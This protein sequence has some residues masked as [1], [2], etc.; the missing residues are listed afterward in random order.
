MVSRNNAL[1]QGINEVRDML[2]QSQEVAVDDDD[3]EYDEEIEFEYPSNIAQTEASEHVLPPADNITRRSRGAED[4]EHK[5]G[6]R[7]GPHSVAFARQEPDIDPSVLRSQLNSDEKQ[8]MR[9]LLEVTTTSMA[10]I[11]IQIG[12]DNS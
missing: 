4:I 6:E 11:A 7:V 8:M 2:K 9:E 10:R 3:D 12:K 5:E 1:T